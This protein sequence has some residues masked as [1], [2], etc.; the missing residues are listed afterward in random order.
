MKRDS[1]GA[2]RAPSDDTSIRTKDGDPAQRR[3]G[4]RVVAFFV[5]MLI[6]TLLAKGIAGTT[7]ARVK[8][9]NP[10]SHTMVQQFS[11]EGI[12]EKSAVLSIGIPEGY[13]VS[14][15]CVEIGSQI[16]TGDVI[17]R[18]DRQDIKDRIARKQAELAEQQAR[19][20]AL[21]ADQNVSYLGVEQA[22]TKVTR[23]N[24]AMNQAN[25]EL[26]ASKTAAQTAEAGLTAAKQ[27]Q[28]EAQTASDQASEEDRSEALRKLEEAK[29][30]VAD[31]GAVLEAAKARQAAAEAG[32]AAAKLQSENAAFA[33]RQ[34]Q[35]SYYEMAQQA[36]QTKENNQAQ[37]QSL[38][39]D[40]E[41]TQRTINELQAFLD[42][43]ACLESE[44]SGSV[45]KIG[46][47]VGQTGTG[48]EEIEIQPESAEKCFRV[49]ITQAQADALS[50]AQSI[51]LFQAEVQCQLNGSALQ[52]EPQA[53]GT[54]LC[55]GTVSHPAIEAG[56]VRMTCMLSS[57]TYQTCVPLSALHTEASGSY[58]FVYAPKTSVLGVQDSAVR[59]D[60]KILETDERFAAVQGSL[61]PKDRIVE[62]SSK[63]LKNG[64]RVRVEP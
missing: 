26:S 18:F 12:V 22:Q 48:F 28:A 9:T 36:A 32:Q 62:S 33:L 53:D 17:L 8:L 2:K 49:Q 23:A 37:A 5:G 52:M 64:D 30:A 61:S 27:A 38:I 24:D 10:G 13:T 20:N 63:A 42:D 45:T 39:L 34:A 21:S 47:R 44:A 14:E 35:T 50:A 6:L 60:V 11:V 31:A 16:E 29:Q 51:L 43:G 7:V 57:N 59:V 4:L 46:L 56:T 3:A 41:Q 25:A 19:L 55:S 54:V 1:S 40:M 15:C 58:V